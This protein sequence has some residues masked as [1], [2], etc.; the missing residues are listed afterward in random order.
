[1]AAGMKKGLC[2]VTMSPGLLGVPDSI[3][4]RKSASLDFAQWPP[5]LLRELCDAMYLVQ[6]RLGGAAIAA[7]QVGV[8]VRLAVIDDRK[9]NSM[10]PKPL[11]LAN[12]VIVER[13][14]DSRWFVEGCLS[15]PGHWARVERARRVRVR[16]QD[17]DGTPIEI[18]AEGPR[19]QLLQHE[20]DHLDGILYADRLGT[21]DELR[22]I[23]SRRLSPLDAAARFRS[24]LVRR[25]AAA[26]CPGSGR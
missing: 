8:S 1:M 6:L 4:R 3:L 20:I 16:A 2:V 23:G 25:V 26:R 19:A 21:V 14:E 18:D 5:G 17:V 12:P 22:S 7:P 15:L 10:T 11:V 13:S 9:P 24:A